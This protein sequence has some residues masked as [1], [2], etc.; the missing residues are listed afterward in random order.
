MLHIS[1]SG[2][3]RNYNNWLRLDLG[4]GHTLRYKDSSSNYHPSTS[5]FSEYLQKAHTMAVG[6]VC[7]HELAT[8]ATVARMILRNQ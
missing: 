5:C 2:A 6:S 4:P 1:A 3:R 8:D 7:E